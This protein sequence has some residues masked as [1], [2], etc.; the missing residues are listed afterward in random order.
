MPYDRRLRATEELQILRMKLLDRLVSRIEAAKERPAEDEL[1]WFAQECVRTGSTC[2]TFNYDDVLDRAL[3]EVDLPKAPFWEPINGYGT[4]MGSSRAVTTPVYASGNL[5]AP[6]LLLKLHGSMNWRPRLGASRPYASGAIVH[7]SQWLMGD[8]EPGEIE[9]IERHLEPE[10]FIVAPTFRKSDLVQEPLLRLI[11]QRAYDKLTAANTVIFVGYS[12]PLTD[13]SAQFLFQEALGP[14][15]RQR[16][17]VVSLSIPPPISGLLDSYKSLFPTLRA[18]N[19]F[20]DGARPWI[21]ESLLPA[22]QSL[23]SVRNQNEPVG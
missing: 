4:I 13:L 7:H 3:T 21:R 2:I 6:T 5:E 15:K 18:S 8:M 14:I 22:M 1:T 17:Y 10:P 11:W 20:F 16:A 19:F 9:L 12:L 23:P